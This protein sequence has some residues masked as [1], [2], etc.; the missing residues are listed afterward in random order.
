[1]AT[2]ITAEAIQQMIQD[3]LAAQ[4]EIHRK[5]L[6]A[7]VARLQNSSAVPTPPASP[8]NSS[9]RSSV[10][11]G[12]RLNMGSPSLVFNDLGGTST[13]E[14]ATA[15]VA[16]AFALA[17]ASS[18]S[19]LSQQNSYDSFARDQTKLEQSLIERKD[20]PVTDSGLL[21]SLKFFDNYNHQGGRRSLREFLGHTWLRTLERVQ[22][23]TIPDESE[24]SGILR[25]FLETVFD[26]LDSFNFRVETDFL[27]L[28]VALVK[29]KVSLD[30]MQTYVAKFAETLED[31]L[32]RFPDPDDRAL[33]KRLVSYF[34]NGIEPEPLRSLIKHFPVAHISEVFPQFRTH[35]TASVVE[36]ANL[37][38]E[39]SLRDR[40]FRSRQLQQIPEQTRPRGGSVKPKRWTQQEPS[41]MLFLRRYFQFSIAITV[42]GP[43]NQ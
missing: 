22:G 42:A 32:P 2:G 29:G 14:M 9:D 25:N 11:K 24:G 30:A 16:R 38:T 17:T 20:D 7:L 3:A 34:Y 6:A 40:Q 31:W 41:R 26:L 18:S 39:K 12:T 19:N 5:E 43:T 21:A 8:T 13:S 36:M 15:A 10:K 33:N 37:K 35:C 27:P 23:V 1:M 28:K 4:A